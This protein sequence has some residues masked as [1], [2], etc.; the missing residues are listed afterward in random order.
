MDKHVHALQP[1]ECFD[2]R[3]WQSLQIKRVEKNEMQTVGVQALDYLF[4]GLLCRT[5]VCARRT[6]GCNQSLFGRFALFNRSIG[7]MNL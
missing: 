6:T 1:G 5:H 3:E 2:H 7:N 4:G